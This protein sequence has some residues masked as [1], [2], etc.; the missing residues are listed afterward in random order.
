MRKIGTMPGEEEAHRFGD[1]LYVKGIENDVEHAEGEGFEIWVHDDAQLDAELPRLYDAIE[2][3]RARRSVFPGRRFAALLSR[4][5]AQVADSTELVERVENA[6][7]VTDDVY[8]ARVYSAARTQSP[9][10]FS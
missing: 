1:F 6:L 7:K 5:Q 9:E 3:A 2:A 8:L 10:F 4:L